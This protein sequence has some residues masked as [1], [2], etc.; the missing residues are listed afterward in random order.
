LASK[1]GKGTGQL[2]IIQDNGEGFLDVVGANQLLIIS[3]GNFGVDKNSQKIKNR[4]AIYGS[5][6]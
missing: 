3:P 2:F 4:K 5:L 6:E 1:Y